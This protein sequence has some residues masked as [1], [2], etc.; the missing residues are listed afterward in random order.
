MAS[1]VGHGE[2]I[3][4][5]LQKGRRWSA[6]ALQWSGGC[7][8]AVDCAGV[9]QVMREELRGF[10]QNFGVAAAAAGDRIQVCARAR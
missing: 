7:P 8:G 4:A 3:R 1:E 9:E 5:A 10:F 6:W 2:E